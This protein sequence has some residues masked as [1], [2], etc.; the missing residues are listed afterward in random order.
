[1]KYQ[2][3]IFD[4]D[5]TLI[6]SEQGI[7][8]SFDFAIR[9]LKLD[10]DLNKNFRDLLGPPLHDG[11]VK[12]LQMTDKEADVGVKYFREYYGQKGVF[13]SVL[14]PGIYDLLKQMYKRGKKLHL[15]TSKLEKYAIAILEHLEIR[16]FFTHISGAA[17]KGPGADKQYL[18]GQ[19]IEK[20][21]AI[22]SGNALM[23]GDTR[24]DVEGAVRNRID[25]W[26]VLYGYGSE[27]ELSDAGAT[28]II[29][30]IDHL[31]MEL[32]T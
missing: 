25:S 15:A 27:Q 6:N 19:I 2:H 18:I 21:P 1:M 26:G 7:R 8:N 9:K 3:F 14:Y 29:N 23:I 24:F 31:M 12:V 10:I 20:L 13:E 11:F 22:E 32:L 30:D 17:Y 5:G 28:R 4:L 16:P